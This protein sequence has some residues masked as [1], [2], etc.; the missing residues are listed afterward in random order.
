MKSYSEIK[1]ST[2][3]LGTFVEVKCLV[4]QDNLDDLHILISD[5]F[6]QIRLWESRLSFFNQESDLVKINSSAYGDQVVVGYEMAAVLKIAALL[7]RKTNGV[8]DVIK[9][10]KTGFYIDDYLWQKQCRIKLLQQVEI[11]LGGIAKGFI[12][13]KAAKF[14]SKKSIGGIINAGGDIRIFGDYVAP[15]HIRDPFDHTKKFLLGNYSNCA[16]ASSCISE[17]SKERGGKSVVYAQQDIVHATVIG[18]N[19]TIADALTKV[20]LLDV[21]NA[22][23]VLHDFGCSAIAIDKDGNFL[24][25]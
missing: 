3:A 19:C 8:F 6:A 13:D 18:K 25:S 2:A 22:A 1:R 21:E 23:Q 9:P 16:I 10:H 24:Q 20:I 5:L 14:L 7:N 4:L 15:I 11:D 17:N 12:V